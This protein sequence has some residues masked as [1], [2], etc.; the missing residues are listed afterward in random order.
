M[1]KDCGCSLGGHDH[2][3]THAD[4]TTH[5]HAHDHGAEHGHGAAHE[6]SHG[7]AHPAL[8]DSKTV[9]VI[10]KILSQNDGTRVIS[11]PLIKISPLV[12]VSNK[13]IVRKKVL[14]PPPLAPIIA[15]TSPFLKFTLISSSTNKSPKRFVKFLISIKLVMSIEPF[16]EQF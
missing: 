11:L 7:H 8:N 3:H 5:S 15:T 13:F 2:T 4:G 16:F 12:G 14:F 10:T 6:H 1:C 9:E